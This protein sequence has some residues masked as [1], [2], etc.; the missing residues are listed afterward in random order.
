MSS[1]CE[2]L[3]G[4]DE[5]AI[6]AQPSVDWRSLSPPYPTLVQRPGQRD[7]EDLVPPS[8]PTLPGMAA[9]NPVLQPSSSQWIKPAQEQNPSV[10]LKR[11]GEPPLSLDLGTETGAPKEESSISFPSHSK[12]WS[13]WRSKALTQ[14]QLTEQS[15]ALMLLLLLLCF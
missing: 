12:G 9:A 1:L 13:S 7:L 4:S 2:R 11:A 10:V 8:L 15:H 5:P 3:H 14:S 6:W